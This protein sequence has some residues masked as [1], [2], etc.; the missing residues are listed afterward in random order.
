M[1]VSRSDETLIQALSFPGPPSLIYLDFHREV[2]GGSSITTLEKHIVTILP[3]IFSAPSISAKNIIITSTANSI[4]TFLTNYDIL[5]IFTR[6]GEIG[7]M[8]TC[9][10]LTS[11]SE[12]D[13][14]NKINSFVRDFIQ[15]ETEKERTEFSVPEYFI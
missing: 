9:G 13:K 8:L 4:I 5:A 1:T 10:T 12:T 2:M 7:T 11:D 14:V 3:D 6:D 15:T